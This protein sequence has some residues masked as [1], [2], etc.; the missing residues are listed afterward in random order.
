MTMSQSLAQCMRDESIDSDNAL[1]VILSVVYELDKYH[2]VGLIHGNISPDTIILSN[3]K[4][5][6]QL[7]PDNRYDMSQKDQQEKRLMYTLSLIHI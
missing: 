7:L 5:T 6:V 2:Q 4:C 3:D 1:Q